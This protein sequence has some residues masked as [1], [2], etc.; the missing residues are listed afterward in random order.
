MQGLFP[1]SCQGDC[2]QPKRGRGGDEATLPE[3]LLCVRCIAS[4]STYDLDCIMSNRIELKAKEVKK[5][6]FLFFF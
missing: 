3:D 4:M 1:R 2:S 5:F 6:S